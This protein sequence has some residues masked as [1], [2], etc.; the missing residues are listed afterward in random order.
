M[1]GVRRLVVPSLLLV[2]A[3]CADSGG[4]PSAG[5]RT[6][7]TVDV[8]EVADALLQDA[9]FVADVVDAVLAD[10]ELTA[11]LLEDAELVDAIAAKVPREVPV[12]VVVASVGLQV[13]AGWLVCDGAEVARADYPELFAT[14]G[15]AHG[16]GDGA[17]TF[18]L[19]DLRG[20]FLRGA[21]E[22]AGND[23]DAAG[24]GAAAPG[25]NVGDL[26][27]TLQGDATGAPEVP[28]EAAE[29]GDHTH[30]STRPSTYSSFSSGGSSYTVWNQSTSGQTGSAGRHVHDITGGDA[31]TRPVNVAVRW[32]VRATP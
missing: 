16:S 13:P 14:L 19:P 31:E 25:G 3:A 5:T 1:R 29:A 24:R 32:L 28:F 15:T 20:R 26:V 27:G 17:T 8:A 11:A 6:L 22:G 18:R 2:G 23:P 30:G 21:D 12:G 10:P 4:Q 7:A 9:D